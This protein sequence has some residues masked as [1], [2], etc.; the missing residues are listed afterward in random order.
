M[1]PTAEVVVRRDYI[2]DLMK[3]RSTLTATKHTAAE[4]D[5]AKA[6]PV[7]LTPP[8]SINW[9]APHFVWQV[10]QA[11]AEVLCPDKPSDCP[12]VDTGGYHVTTTLDWKMQQTVD[13]W[14]YA[15][16]RAPEREGPAGRPSHEEDPDR[17]WNW[18]LGL[19]GHNINNAAAGVIDYRTGEVLAYAG[20]ASYTSKG[21]TKFQPQFDVMSDG[22][23]QPGSA[24]KP[25]DYLIGID[26]ETLTA[27]TMFMDVFT[28][29]GNNYTPIQAD[30]AERGPVRL[31]SALQFSL[32]VPA[33]K[34]TLITGLE[35]HV[36]SPEGLRPALPVRNRAGA[37]RW[38]SGRSRSTRSTCSAPTGPSRTAASTCRAR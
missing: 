36:R 24:I 2:L 23:R 31:R 21:N 15:A 9:K 32:N 8:A 33:I 34:A 10:R 18:I 1:P 25:I 37:G 5:A 3:T 13:K 19:R 30:K 11:L 20:S 22:W 28:N 16:A 6:E 12:Q 26:D 7:E 17:D 35:P 4:Y 38:A 27:S 29:F 14:V